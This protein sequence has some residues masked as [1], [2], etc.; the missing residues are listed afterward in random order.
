MSA[1][2]D[3]P[4][5]AATVIGVI[6][7]MEPSARL[8]SL[9]KGIVDRMYGGSSSVGIVAT[10]DILAL[11]SVFQESRIAFLSHQPRLLVSAKTYVLHKLLTRRPFHYIT[12][13]VLIDMRRYILLL[14][15]VLRSFKDEP[16][17]ITIEHVTR[18]IWYYQ[19]INKISHDLERAGRDRS[20]DLT[21]EWWDAKIT[22]KHCQYM[23]LSMGDS[24]S[25]EEL[26]WE[27]TELVIQGVLQVRGSHYGDA[28]ATLNEILKGQRKRE[29]WHRDYMELEVLYFKT[30]GHAKEISDP[31]G[32]REINTVVALRNKLEMEFARK[33]GRHSPILTRFQRGWR[34]I[35]RSVRASGPYEEHDYYFE[36]LLVDLLYTASFR[37]PMDCR[38]T[39]FD[40]MVGGVRSALEWSHES[41]APLHLKATDLYRRID[42]L[43]KDDQVDYIKVE[44]RKFIEQWINKHPGNS[45]NK[46]N[47]MG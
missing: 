26:V 33:T 27:R 37:L 18:G 2:S 19:G 45:E 25:R 31:Q 13:E 35:G 36:Y 22:L 42:R 7:P 40:E 34:E 21:I 28:Q 3:P 6:V 38:R 4:S 39:C 5:M 12:P 32:Q 23:L 1:N 9:A 15:E 14:A 17:V 30:F 11:L 20:G 8:L 43:A 16:R 46:T 47:S 41:A 44:H 29:P 10:E 24:F